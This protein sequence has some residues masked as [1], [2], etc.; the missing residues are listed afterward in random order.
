MSCALG[1]WEV[2]PRDFSYWDTAESGRRGERQEVGT[3]RNQDG[4]QST[5]W[6][7]PW[8]LCVTLLFSVVFLIVKIARAL[9]KNKT[10]PQNQKRGTQNTKYEIHTSPA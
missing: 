1:I 7:R 5:G 2:T 4:A 9:G 8:T 10:T 3:K 6:G